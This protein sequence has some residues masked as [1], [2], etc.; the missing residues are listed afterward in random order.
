MANIPA[1]MVP[2]P[3]GMRVLSVEE[4]RRV[5]DV[6]R[7]A[8]R[9]HNVTGWQADEISFGALAAVGVFV[10]PPA[11]ESG[12]CTAQFVPHED[13]PEAADILGVWQQ[14]GMD[15]GHDPADGHEGADTGWPDGAP[16]SIPARP[17]EA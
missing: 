7:A 17:V 1:S 10:Q 6:V 3:A 2:L 12:T 5:H 16:G 15:V 14:C 13:N 4:M 9:R 8:A 11:A